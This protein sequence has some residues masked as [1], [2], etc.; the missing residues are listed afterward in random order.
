MI[1]KCA[2]K[3]AYKNYMCT[4]II[5]THYFYLYIYIYIYHKI[6]CRLVVGGWGY[7][8]M[9]VLFRYV[10]SKHVYVV[11]YYNVEDSPYCV[12]RAAVIPSMR[13]RDEPHSAWVCLEKVSVEVYCAHC[14]CMAG[15]VF[16]SH[17]YTKANTY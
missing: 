9:Y 4:I 13:T 16:F 11:Y 2:L 5:N 17:K 14:T 1:L 10:E 15:Y 12:L 3:Q 8:H 7:K 6:T